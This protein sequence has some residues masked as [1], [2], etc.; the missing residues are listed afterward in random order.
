MRWSISILPEIFQIVAVLLPSFRRLA[1]VITHPATRA[2]LADADTD[3]DASSADAPAAPAC[4]PLCGLARL[5]PAAGAS[6]DASGPPIGIN[7]A[8]TTTLATLPSQTRR[9]SGRQA[10]AP[11]RASLGVEPCVG[12]VAPLP[13]AASAVPSPSPYAEL[14]PPPGV[15]VCLEDA[16]LAPSPDSAD[17]ANGTP[18]HPPPPQAPSRTDHGAFAPVDLSVVRGE[19]LMLCGAIG[20]GK[21][22]LLAALSRARPPLRGRARAIASRAYV[23]QHPFLLRASVRDNITFGLPMRPA[24]YREAL[25]LAALEADLRVL[26]EGDA[27]DAGEAGSH[28]SGGQR[29]RVALARAIYSDAEALFLDDVFAAVDAHVGGEVP[30]AT[31]E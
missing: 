6:L 14:A 31:Q 12:S 9:T 18:L 29:A 25:S 13:Q 17:P 26:P 8:R 4:S 21:S 30:L 19:M 15:A 27:T 28:L 16:M 24:A 2:A 23:E 1:A 20:C 22:T 10:R 5:P 11:P 7:G 3:A